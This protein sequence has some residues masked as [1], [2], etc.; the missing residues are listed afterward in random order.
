MGD[1]QYQWNVILMG[2]L[3]IFHSWGFQDSL[4]VDS[5]LGDLVGSGFSPSSKYESVGVELLLGWG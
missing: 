3:T 5:S 2:I 1:S 4:H